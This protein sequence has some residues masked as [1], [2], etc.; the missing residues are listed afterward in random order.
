MQLRGLGMK[1]MKLSSKLSKPHDIGT[2]WK[3][4]EEIFMIQLVL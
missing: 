3:A 2:H 1:V 4:L